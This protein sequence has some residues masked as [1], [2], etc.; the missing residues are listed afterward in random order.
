MSIFDDI[1]GLAH[2]IEDAVKGE[3]TK[4]ETTLG[5][6][7]PTI[8]AAGS[9]TL[10]EVQADATKVATD[11]HDALKDILPAFWDVKHPSADLFAKGKAA[12]DAFEAWVKAQI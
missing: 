9:K 6:E 12:L 7:L 5:A 10:A 3:V 11:L 2:K 8:E 4:V 1:T